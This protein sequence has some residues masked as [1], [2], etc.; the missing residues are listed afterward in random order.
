MKLF[1]LSHQRAGSSNLARFFSKIYGYK[2]GMEAL[3]DRPISKRIK[4]W[5]F[6]THKDFIKIATIYSKKFDMIKHIYGTYPFVIDELLLRN[7]QSEKWIFLQR[8]NLN[9]AAL[10]AFIASQAESWSSS[11]D[12]KDLDVPLSQIKRK[13]EAYDHGIRLTRDFLDSN[14]IAYIPLYYE[15]I[16]HENSEKRY[17]NI[18]HL[19]KTLGFNIVGESEYEKAYNEYIFVSKK[20][21]TKESLRTIKNWNQLSSTLNFD[22]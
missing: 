2:L 7:I 3:N 12:L 11:I 5:K 4:K 19:I 10:S 17:D 9:Y 13:V 14:Q 1:L 16:Y 15:D 18:K 8:R 21:N 22:Y 6:M 20:I